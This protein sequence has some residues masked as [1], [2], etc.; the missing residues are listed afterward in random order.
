MTEIFTSRNY[1]V[2]YSKSVLGLKGHFPKE[3]FSIEIL[4]MP[5]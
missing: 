5:G 2:N 1:N 4:P 3:L